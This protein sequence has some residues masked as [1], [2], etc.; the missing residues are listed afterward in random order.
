MEYV[1]QPMDDFVQQLLADYIHSG[2]DNTH[3][4][5]VKSMKYERL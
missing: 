4:V 5:F 3:R 2:H 1:R